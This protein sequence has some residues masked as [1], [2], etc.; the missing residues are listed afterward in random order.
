MEDSCEHADDTDL[1][2]GHDV[3]FVQVQLSCSQLL[4]LVA[5]HLLVQQDF[6]VLLRQHP[7]HGRGK[8][9][10]S[11]QMVRPGEHSAMTPETN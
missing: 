5:D 10:T 2:Q 4:L 6:L 11:G 3:A 8:E 1:L 7:L 9:G